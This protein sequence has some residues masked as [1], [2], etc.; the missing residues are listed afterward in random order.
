[1]RH[2]KQIFKGACGSYINIQIS[3]FFVVKCYKLASQYQWNCLKTKMDY[4]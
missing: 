1:M 3:S 4:C 2:Q